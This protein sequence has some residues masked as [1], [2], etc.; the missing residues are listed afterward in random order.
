MNIIHRITPTLALAFLGAAGPLS[1]QSELP[2]GL[3]IL[4]EVP[5]Q[6]FSLTRAQFME[7][8]RHWPAGAMRD[9]AEGLVGGTESARTANPQLYRLILDYYG[10]HLD[11]ARGVDVPAAFAT[12]P[13]AEGEPEG[14]WTL[15]CLA[16]H[17]GSVA[18]EYHAG[19]ANST[20]MLER[21]VNDVVAEK[22]DDGAGLDEGMVMAQLG[23]TIGTTEATLFGELLLRFR[24]PNMDLKPL[25]GLVRGGTQNMAR[26]N[27]LPDGLL[28]LDAPAWWQLQHK[29]HLYLDHS[30]EKNHRTVM[31]FTL[32]VEDMTF[33][34]EVRDT[35]ANGTEAEVA[36]TLG[37]IAAREVLALRSSYVRKAAGGEV[38]QD[39]LLAHIAKAIPAM[40]FLA[41]LVLARFVEPSGISGETVR[42]WDDEFQSIFAFID[43][44]EA[45]VYPGAIDSELAAQ[46]Q[47]LFNASC[48]RC[49]GHYDG[50]GPAYASKR[51]DAGVIGTDAL[52]P[53]ALDQ[54]FRDSLVG[55]LTEG[56]DGTQVDIASDVV[57]DEGYVAPPLQGIWAS[58]PYL[59]NGSVP[60]VEHL[61][62]YEL[63]MDLEDRGVHAW[64]A[65]D[66]DAY[67]H[68]GLG[69]AAR[70]LGAKEHVARRFD[71]R[72]RSSKR[73]G[74]SAGG[75]DFGEAL[76]GA[77]RRAIVEYLKTL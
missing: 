41:K 15:N 12:P 65:D 23:H 48:A 71:H 62:H 59:H 57:A 3:R 10:L 37:T 16:C 51:I 24:E 6:S 44:L 22:R 18:G 49:H 40:P 29:T 76:D 28:A 52:Y 55:F 63:R 73:R 25:P 11:S 32:G 35:V 67:D 2:E 42:G 46:G 74:M 43:G 72:V 9:A 45:P 50:S 66:V 54:S 33:K 26:L 17:G 61:L 21:L 30:V 64:V 7:L 58:A 13:L 68:E 20:L 56:P 4:Y 53:T 60:T 19:L 39:K 38:D 27:A 8:W 14:I 77:E 70:F 34:S 75:H 5:M 1:A 31:Q 69:L 47:G 36:E